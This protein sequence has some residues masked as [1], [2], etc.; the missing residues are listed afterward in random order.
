MIMI[1]MMTFTS[2][3]MTVTQKKHCLVPTGY[4]RFTPKTKLPSYLCRNT[5]TP[6]RNTTASTAATGT[7][8]TY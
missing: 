4:H 8:G 3:D 7:C 6:S 2:C 1:M 5:V